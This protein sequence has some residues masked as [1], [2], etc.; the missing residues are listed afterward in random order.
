M[1][2]GVS[3]SPV[4]SDTG[5]QLHTCAG[6]VARLD[7]RV[8]DFA[9][10]LVFVRVM[11]VRAFARPRR[12]GGSGVEAPAMVAWA[13]SA[14]IPVQA[15]R[16]DMVAEAVAA[17]RRQ[18]AELFNGRGGAGRGGWRLPGAF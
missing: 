4:Q 7:G 8:I 3:Q 10:V 13:S 9:D 2:Q 11:L 16:T 12:L 5:Q 15:H 14:G 6:G 17:R 1:K 18:G